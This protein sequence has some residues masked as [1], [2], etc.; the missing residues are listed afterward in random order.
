MMKINDYLVDW[1]EQVRTLAVQQS[2]K[3]TQK[4]LMALAEECGRITLLMEPERD[5]TRLH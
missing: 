2:D 1:A 5:L 4:K 3:K